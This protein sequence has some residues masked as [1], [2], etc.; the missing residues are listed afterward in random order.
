MR[1]SAEISMYPLDKNYEVPIID[2][3]ERLNEHPELSVKTNTM[4]TQVFGDYDDLMRILTKE[5]KV[6]FAGKEKMSVVIKLLN[7]DV[8]GEYVPK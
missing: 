5:M 2:F 4:S 8:E 7:M 6:S 1:A 3:I